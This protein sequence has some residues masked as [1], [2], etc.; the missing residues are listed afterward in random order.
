MVHI[1]MKKMLIMFM[2]FELIKC[3]TE[4]DDVCFPD[5][6]AN[7]G[8]VSSSSG[9]SQGSSG[10][11]TPSLGGLFAAGF[12]TLRPIGQRDLAGKTTGQ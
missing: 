8:D 11:V 10:G 4:D 2:N 7:T 5:P 6:K 1:K 12:P 9:A 3:A